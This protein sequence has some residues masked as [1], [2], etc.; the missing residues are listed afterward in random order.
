MLS[1]P[2]NIRSRLTG[3]LFTMNSPPPPH[4]RRKKKRRKE[5]RKKKPCEILTIKSEFTDKLLL[6]KKSESLGQKQILFSARYFPMARTGSQPEKVRLLVG[7]LRFIRKKKVGISDKL[8]YIKGQENLSFRSLRGLTDSTF[9]CEKR[10]IP[11]VG[12]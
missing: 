4:P 1:P 3:S 9:G 5:R 8:R 6:R 12:Q 7:A 2:R 11:A 10:K